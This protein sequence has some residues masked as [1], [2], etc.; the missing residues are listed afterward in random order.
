[1]TFF[2]YI[3]KILTYLVRNEMK[4]DTNYSHANS[5]ACSVCCF[6]V[7]RQPLVICRLIN[8]STADLFRNPPD[9]DSGVYFQSAHASLTTQLG[10]GR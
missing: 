9:T 4:Y 2:Q 8:C 6:V 3:L 5:V 7:S 10:Y 1:M